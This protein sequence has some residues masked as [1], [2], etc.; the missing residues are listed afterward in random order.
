MSTEALHQ[1][2]PTIADL[3]KG[4]NLL[5]VI[6]IIYFAGRKSI[7]LALRERHDVT[8]RRLVD[9]KAELEK[10][11]VE[12]ARFREEI[13]HMS[14]TKRKLVS[15][16]EEEGR[17]LAGNIIAEAQA[18]AKRILEETKSAAEYEVRAASN[19]L[20]AKL[21]GDAIMESTQIIRSDSG[22]IKNK[23]HDRLIERFLTDSPDEIS[24][25]KPESVEARE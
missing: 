10:M 17:K 21:V 15:E 24:P 9:A 22:E 7:A 4:V 6:A 16:V 1:M 14:D 13:S 11:K 12:A 20:R 5:V 18:T 19:R 2:G 3:V 8:K 23:I 25:V